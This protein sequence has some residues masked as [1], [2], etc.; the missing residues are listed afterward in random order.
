MSEQISEPPEMTSIAAAKLDWKLATQEGNKLCSTINKL[1]KANKDNDEFKTDI[2]LAMNE[3][4]DTIFNIINS[5]VPSLGEH[6]ELKGLE[7]IHRPDWGR[8]FLTSDEL[9]PENKIILSGLKLL[10]NS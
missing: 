6:L 10:K 4:L 1:M 3:F 9:R 7:Q 5:K 2:I 8:A